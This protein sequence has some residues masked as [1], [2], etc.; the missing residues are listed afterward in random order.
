MDELI[1]NLAQVGDVPAEW[2]FEGVFPT[3]AV[4]HGRKLSRDDT[5]G[6]TVQRVNNHQ[7]SPWVGRTHLLAGVRDAC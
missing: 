2:G 4:L 6:V 7:A 3:N 1:A 5:T